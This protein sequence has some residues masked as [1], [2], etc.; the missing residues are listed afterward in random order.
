M[1]ALIV[2]IVIGLYLGHHWGT[3]TALFRLGRAEHR[4]RTE[5]IKSV[6]LWNRDR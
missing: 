6:S 2:G 1:V 5:A 3:R 4:N